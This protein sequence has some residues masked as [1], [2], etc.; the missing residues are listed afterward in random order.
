MSRCR[1]VKELQ[2]AFLTSDSPH[3]PSVHRSEAQLRGIRYEKAAKRILEEQ[4]NHE[5]IPG[6]WF[7]YREKRRRGHFCQPDGLIIQP[8]HRRIIITEIKL[9]HTQDAYFQLFDLY[10]PVVM[11]TFGKEWRYGC[12]EI[13]RWYDPAEPTPEPP[14]LCR[15]PH[16]VNPGVFGVHICRA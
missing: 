8:R 11:K 7:W 12:V 5:F 13:V 9:R 4:Y 14:A 16:V 2:Y 15:E 10:L 1:R 3:F 6:P